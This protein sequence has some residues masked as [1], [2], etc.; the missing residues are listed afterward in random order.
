LAYPNATDLAT[1]ATP[2]IPT[3]FASRIAS[4]K[5]TGYLEFVDIYAHSE[6][7]FHPPYSVPTIKYA[8]SISQPFAITE[9][10]SL[11][12]LTLAAPKFKGKVLVTTG[13]FDLGVCGG[14]CK[15]TFAAGGEKQVFA[16][17]K[18]VETYLHPGAG[19]GVNFA[20][21]AS[22]FYD[23]ITSFLDRNF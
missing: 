20:A 14:E 23:V 8:Q 1:L 19:H 3:A 18:T 21:N 13:E 22:G 10:L 2:W 11:N 15:S 7:F 9:L 16:G 17:A 5:D 12:T 6:T 4:K